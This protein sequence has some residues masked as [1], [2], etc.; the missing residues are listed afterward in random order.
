[1]R[2]YALHMALCRAPKVR[3]TNGVVRHKLRKLQRTNL[4]R[5]RFEFN[6]RFRR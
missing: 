3:I 5:L 4:R 1:M 6:R 2:M